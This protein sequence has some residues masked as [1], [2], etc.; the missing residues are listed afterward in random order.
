MP[1]HTIRPKKLH[2]QVFFMQLQGTK[3]FSFKSNQPTWLERNLWTRNK[4]FKKA[5]K[6]FGQKSFFFKIIDGIRTVN[7]NGHIATFS[8]ILTKSEVKTWV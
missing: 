5:T 1:K 7:M 6:L 8:F 4:T 2:G 3:A